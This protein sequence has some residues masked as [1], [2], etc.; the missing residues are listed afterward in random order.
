MTLAADY[1]DRLA[2]PYCHAPVRK[3]GHWSMENGEFFFDAVPLICGERQVLPRRNARKWT[4]VTLMRDKTDKR[5]G[6]VIGQEP[7]ERYHYIATHECVGDIYLDTG[8][9]AGLL[10]QVEDCEPYRGEIHHWMNAPEG[11]VETGPLHVGAV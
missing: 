10:L 2:C 7:I 3:R 6:E 9:T 4:H 1:T 5:T 8:C 11:L